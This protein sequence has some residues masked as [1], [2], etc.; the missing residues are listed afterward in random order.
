MGGGMFGVSSF[1][2]EYGALCWAS[3]VM[4]GMVVSGQHGLF[5]LWFCIVWSFVGYGIG[6]CWAFSFG[7]VPW[8]LLTIWHVLFLLPFA[9]LA[10][11]VAEKR[12]VAKPAILAGVFTLGEYLR[13][14]GPTGVSMVTAS[15]PLARNL[16]AVQWASITGAAGLSFAIVFSGLLM[17][18]AVVSRGCERRV[19]TAFS[20]AVLAIILLGGCGFLL[21]ETSTTRYV[22][23]AALQGVTYNAFKQL[24]PSKDILTVYVELTEKA[25][26]ENRAELMVWPETS[27]PGIPSSTNEITAAVSG[28]IQNFNAAAL[29]GAL[30]IDQHGHER[31]YRNMALGYD[32][33][34][35]LQGICE[36][37]RLTPF[38][39]YV[40]GRS[41]LPS[42]ERWGV[43]DQ[44]Y[45]TGHQ[46]PPIHL[47]GASVG[48]LICSESMFSDLAIQWI[49]KKADILIV[50]SNDSW[51]GQSGAEQ[52]ARQSIL[53]AVET[54]RSVARAAETGYSMMI[55]PKGRVLA[56]SSLNKRMVVSAS[57]PLVIGK[58]FFAQ[59]PYAAPFVMLLIIIGALLLNRSDAVGQP[60]A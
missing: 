55:S 43:P 30:Y 46:S 36:K 3:I 38:G 41:F 24:T 21:Q 53:R 28:G 17:G 44:D 22:R 48:T 57:L 34:G 31:R 56:Q 18:C 49:N 47:A 32:R 6:L 4:L 26:K 42:L 35:R 5:R 60:R 2:N 51:F 1:I 9:I 29:I 40:P 59:A 11:R 25:V 7:F 54:R 39:E 58:T 20:I 10:N 12:P 27:F 14:W 37:A 23:T 8:G 50:M 16:P 45:L 15:C 52:L 13:G 33:N 19:C